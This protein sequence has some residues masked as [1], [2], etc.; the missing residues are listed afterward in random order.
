M[1]GCGRA[2]PLPVLPANVYP[3]LVEVPPDGVHDGFVV[4]A[5]STRNAIEGLGNMSSCLGSPDVRRNLPERYRPA[6]VRGYDAG[7]P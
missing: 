2:R 1:S 5:T 7:Q 6:A 4:M 3:V